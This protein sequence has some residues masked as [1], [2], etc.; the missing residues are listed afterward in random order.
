MH[1]ETID[2]RTISEA[3]ARAAAE[4]L[5]AIWPKPGRTVES[6][7]ADQL[8]RS[9]AYGGPEAQHPRSFFIR[10]AGR[11]IAHASALPRTLGTNAGDL[12]VLALAR[13]CTDPAVRGRH[14]GQAMVRAAFELVDSGTFPFAL[15]Q[16]KETV[17][18]FYE[19]LGA[20]AVDNPFVD[21]TADN[22]KAWPFWDAAIMRYPAKPGWPAGEIDLRGPGW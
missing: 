13:V 19:R 11:V 17:R 4:L 9:K 10:E 3:D 2:L 8:Q 18:P 5:C 12:T 15:F 14:L 1:I 21:S 7:T 16:T 22:P 20:I 6:L